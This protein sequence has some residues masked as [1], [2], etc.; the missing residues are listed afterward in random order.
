MMLD[1]AVDDRFR[2][3]ALPLPGAPPGFV[4]DGRGTGSYAIAAYRLP[5]LNVMPFFGGEMYDP[6]PQGQGASDALWGGLNVRPTPRV[7]LKAQLTHAWTPD[8]AAI[9]GD[10]TYWVLDLQSAWS[11]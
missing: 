5:W 2:Q 1:T 10:N 3:A 6:G 7:V 8:D 11:F 9:L 4:P